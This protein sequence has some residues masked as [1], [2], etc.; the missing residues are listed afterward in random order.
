MATWLMG[1]I[2]GCAAELA[3]LVDALALAAGDRVVALGD[4]VHRGPDPLGVVRLLGQVG[5]EFV[6]GNHEH[7]FL[8][9]NGLAPR[10]AA[11]R[12][13][14]PWTPAELVGDAGRA[15][16]VAP[17]DAPEVVGFLLGSAGYFLEG[18]GEGGRWSAVHAGVTPGKEARDSEV[19]D[20]VYPARLAERGRPF[21]FERYEGEA[22]VVFGHLAREQPIVMKRAGRTVAVGVDTGCVLG[23]KLTAYSPERDEFREVRAR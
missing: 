10:E 14:R 2:H 5:A 9:R 21:W 23:G 11:G 3:R 22:L 7:V 20:L 17:G 8:R 15:L 18:A 4:L 1:D 19:E 16:C 12:E 13:R 6:L